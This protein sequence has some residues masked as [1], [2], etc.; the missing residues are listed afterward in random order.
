MFKNFKFSLFAKILLFYICVFLVPFLICGSFLTQYTMSSYKNEVLDLNFNTVNYI[1]RMIDENIEDITAIRLQISKNEEIMNFVRRSDMPHKEKAYYAKQVAEEI[2]KYRLYKSTIREIHLYSSTADCIITKSTYY[3]KEEYYNKFLTSSGMSFEEWCEKLSS[4]QMPPTPI[5][6][7]VSSDTVPEE[8]KV[9]TATIMQP[10]IRDYKGNTATLLVVLDAEYI[11]NTYKGL[12]SE[13]YTPYFAISSATDILIESDKAPVKLDA[14]KLFYSN[15]EMQNAEDGHVIFTSNSQVLDLNYIC[16]MSEKQIL[17]RVRSISRFL[18]LSIMLMSMILILLAYVFS[19]KT[20]M[21][22][23]TLT[24]LGIGN[25]NYRFESLKEFQGFLVNIV[26]SN[27]QLSEVVNKQ[28]ECINDNFFKAFVQ[29]SMSVDENTLNTLFSDTSISVK[30]DCFRVAIVD[31]KEHEKDFNGMESLNIISYFQDT[32]KEYNISLCVV[33]NENKQIIL[34][35]SYDKG[36]GAVKPALEKIAGELERTENIKPLIGVGRVINSLNKFTKSYEDAFFELRRNTSGV[37]VF[38]GTTNISYSE[39]FNFIKKDKLIFDVRSGNEEAVE[40]FFSNLKSGI[41]TNYT[42]TYGIQNYVRYLLEGIFREAVN[43]ENTGDA[44]LKKY[45]SD[46]SKALETQSVTESFEL[47]EKCF[48]GAARCMNEANSEK[49][50]DVINDII[51]YVKK[52]FSDP[53]LS[54]KQISEELNIA[55][56]KYISEAFKRRVGMKFTDYLHDVRNEEAKRLL[57]STDLMVFEIA[58]KVGYLGSNAFVKN[59]K[60]LN[61]I[62]PGDFRKSG[63]V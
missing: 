53:D 48:V 59:F 56:Y 50:N 15:G 60:K 54:L 13:E 62:T 11:V 49:N 55:S 18:M 21:P 34:L 37:S 39:Y 26:N 57:L 25:K 36:S 23:K 61:G 63:K 9:T 5:A 19:N 6:S 22:I 51:S 16:V 58:E 40:E 42:T 44:R 20:F 29:N 7:L 45:L 10:V 2:D 30:A 28:K 52:N 32:L 46:C 43:T 31:F 14:G 8:D 33:P 12:V 4:E 3:T 38:E 17:S 41:F 1:R 47:L 35:L 27:K 24:T